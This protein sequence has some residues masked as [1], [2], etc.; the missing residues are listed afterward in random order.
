MLSLKPESENAEE[1]HFQVKWTDRTQKKAHEPETLI[2]LYQ[3]MKLGQ[4]VTSDNN[5]RGS[6]WNMEGDRGGGEQRRMGVYNC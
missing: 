5:A 1:N 4:I 6:G 2:P 3:A